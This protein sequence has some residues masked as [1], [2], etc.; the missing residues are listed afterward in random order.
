MAFNRYGSKKGSVKVFSEPL[1]DAKKEAFFLE[2]SRQF[3][4]SI[5]E[6]IKK[7]EVSNAQ[8]ELTRKADPEFNQR[9]KDIES[10]FLDII[11]EQALRLAMKGD[12]SMVRFVLQAQRPEKYG[13]GAKNEA[14]VVDSDEDLQALSDDEFE[15]LCQAHSS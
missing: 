8:F 1:S 12:A 6:A 2:Y 13:R 4:P 10:R 3:E 7:I 5:E 14:P 9:I 15:K 11:E